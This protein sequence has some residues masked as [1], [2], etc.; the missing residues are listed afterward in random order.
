MFG[1]LVETISTHF[2]GNNLLLNMFFGVC[3]YTL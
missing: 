3:S 2:Q 1:F